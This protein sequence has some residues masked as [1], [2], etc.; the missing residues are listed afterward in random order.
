M[1]I[2]ATTKNQ[3]AYYAYLRTSLWKEKREEALQRDLYRCRLCNSSRKLEVHHRK[4]PKV[5]GEELISDLTTLCGNCHA[6]YETSRKKIKKPR[7]KKTDPFHKARHQEKQKT[8]SARDKHI[9][10]LKKEHLE[11]M[12]KTG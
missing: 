10:L 5:Y 1:A 9:V 2:K 7:R 8:K 12:L 3:E 6:L 11:R 4:Y